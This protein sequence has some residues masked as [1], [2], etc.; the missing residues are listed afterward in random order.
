MI[1]RFLDRFRR[2]PDPWRAEVDALETELA[3]P[4]ESRDLD[5]L[6]PVILPSAC[7]EAAWPGPIVPLGSLP[8]AVAWTTVPEP[9][10]FVYVTDDQAAHWQDLGI[11]WRS[12]AMR[13]LAAIAAPRP[14]SGEKCDDA[15]RPFVLALLHD[16]AMGPSRLLLPNL[17][18]EVLGADYRVAIP[19]RTCAIAYRTNLDSS[20]KADVDSMIEGC[21]RDGTEPMCP[22]RFDPR[23]FWI[24]DEAGGPAAG[25]PT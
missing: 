19:E 9:N 1:A 8:F 2:R 11:G 18:D 23:D 7:L 22:E 20:Q 3:R 25:G 10:R 12:R 16:D 24:F 14:W 17:F 5:T 4:P 13:N 6:F 15:G 21:F